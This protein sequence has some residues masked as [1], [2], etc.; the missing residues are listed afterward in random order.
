M[1]K[2][3]QYANSLKCG[4]LTKSGSSSRIYG[5]NDNRL[6]NRSFRRDLQRDFISFIIKGVCIIYTERSIFCVSTTLLSPTP[7][8]DITSKKTGG[9]GNVKLELADVIDLDSLQ[10]I[11]DYR[12]RSEERRVGKECRSRWSPYH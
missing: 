5:R 4:F 6:P 7:R 8:T 11:Q 1:T 3:Y 12:S 10:E 2:I 9:G